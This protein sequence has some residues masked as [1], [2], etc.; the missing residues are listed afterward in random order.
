MEITANAIQTVA[1]NQNILFPTT[2]VPGS[3]SMVHRI[4]SGLVTLRGLGQQAR[5]RFQIWFG[6][7]VAVSAGE[8]LAPILLAIT[9]GGET[10]PATQMIVTPAAVEDFF[11]V[12]ASVFLDIPSGCCQSISVKN[13]GTT[14]IDVQNANLIIERV[15]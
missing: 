15:A 9:L 10:L 5:A 1:A 7:N 6:G 3:C 14:D 2:T 8:T 4:G 13:I 12:S 11:N